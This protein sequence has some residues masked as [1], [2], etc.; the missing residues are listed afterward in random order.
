MKQANAKLRPDGRWEARAVING[1]RQSFYGERQQ[2][3]IKAMR[4]AQ[5]AADDGIYTEP[6]RFTLAKWLEI[7]RAHV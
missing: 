1:K 7:G 5:K 3:A 4:A 6:T 2:D